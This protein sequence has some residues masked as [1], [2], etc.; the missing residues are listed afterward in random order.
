MDGTLKQCLE[1]FSKKWHFGESGASDISLRRQIANFIGVDDGTIYR[2]CQG[3]CLPKGEPLLRLQHFL[4]CLGYGVYELQSLDKEV[5]KAGQ[6][7]LINRI[8]PI[9]VAN[10]IG[11]DMDGF[12]RAMF[13]KRMLSPER[14]EKLESFCLSCE[15]DFSG[16][17]SKFE[18]RFSGLFISNETL[19]RDVKAEKGKENKNVDFIASLILEIMPLLE[20]I[21]KDGTKEERDRLREIT[22]TQGGRSNAIF[23]LSNILNRLCSERARREIQ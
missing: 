10:I 6:Y 7:I 16:N 1:H 8:L 22:K 13:G 23:E 21:D 3:V 15:V 5:F 18:K 2:W 9:T 12:Y 14:M 4:S 20:K 17:F 19:V 11:I